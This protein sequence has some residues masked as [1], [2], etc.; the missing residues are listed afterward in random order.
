MIPPYYEDDN[1]LKDG[2]IVWTS[3]HCT[4]ISEKEIDILSMFHK[5]APEGVGSFLCLFLLKKLRRQLPDRLNLYLPVKYFSAF[6]LNLDFS[7]SQW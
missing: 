6:G 2:K 7:L 3:S 1:R 5:K 4:K